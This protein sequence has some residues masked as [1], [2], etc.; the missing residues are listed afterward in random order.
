MMDPRNTLENWRNL[1]NVRQFLI[2]KL[3]AKNAA[4]EAKLAALQARVSLY[5]ARERL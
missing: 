1:A 2:N 5:E 3:D 4:L